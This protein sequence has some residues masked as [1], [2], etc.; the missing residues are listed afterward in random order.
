MKKIVVLGS[1]GQLGSCFRDIE[2][3]FTDYDLHF[4]SSKQI[5]ITDFVKIEQ[6]FSK[7][8]FNYCI[9]CAAYTSVDLAEEEKDKAFKVNV[10]GIKNL[11]EV[12]NKFNVCL[13]SFSTDYVFDGKQKKPYTELCKP[14]PIN[15]YGKTKFEGEK[16]ILNS[17]NKFFI[18]RVSWLYSRNGNNFIKTI[19]NLTKTK[20]EIGVVSDQ[21]GTPTSA[22][23]LVYFVLHI[24]KLD[25]KDYGLYHFSNRGIVSWYDIAKSI[26]KN[27]NLTTTIKPIGTNEFITKANRPNFSCLN[28]TKTENTF[29]FFIEDWEKELKKHLSN[30]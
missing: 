22:E 23:S 29:N 8:K 10:E 4:F 24:I 3:E 9:N 6:I 15:Y 5:D 1:N 12:C 27:L 13:V 25:S 21:Y 18:I 16:A 2:F 19:I 11:V 14:N 28:L 26:I 20:K 7:F 30:E 17:S